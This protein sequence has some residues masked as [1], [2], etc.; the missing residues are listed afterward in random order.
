[1][2]SEAGFLEA[3]WALTARRDPK[4][5]ELSFSEPKVGLRCQDHGPSGM[6][7]CVTE[8]AGGIPGAASPPSRPQV[9]AA[10]S[11]LLMDSSGHGAKKREQVFMPPKNPPLKP[12]GEK[13]TA[14]PEFRPCRGAGQWGGDA[15]PAPGILMPPPWALRTSLQSE[16]PPHAAAVAPNRLPEVVGSSEHLDTSQLQHRA[17]SLPHPFSLKSQELLAAA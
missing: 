13:D 9:Q 14:L 16:N 1:M 2:R 10:Q 4:G 12:G 6:L 15:G 17:C 3:S 8:T 11:V 7:G 5:M